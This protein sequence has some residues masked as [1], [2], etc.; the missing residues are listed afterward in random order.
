MI[1]AEIIKETVEAVSDVKDISVKSRKRNIVDLR[2]VYVKLCYEF[3]NKPS[4]SIIGKHIN[5]S[6]CDILYLKDGADVVMSSKKFTAL[7]VYLSCKNHLKNSDNED[8]LNILDLKTIFEV[9]Q[10]Y[11]LRHIRNIEIYH[12]YINTLIKRIET[13]KSNSFLKKCQDLT[14]QELKEL[15]FKFNTFFKVKEKLRNSVD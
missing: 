12:K 3:I 9:K 8:T 2:Y 5:R 1:T 11:R 14:P 4:P 15:E 6:H 10:Y 13:N 7:G